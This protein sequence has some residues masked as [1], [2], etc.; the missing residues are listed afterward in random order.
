M[1]GPRNMKCASRCVAGRASNCVAGFGSPTDSFVNDRYGSSSV[2][3]LFRK[4]MPNRA[5]LV[6]FEPNAWMSEIDTVRARSFR[7]SV[8]GEVKVDGSGKGSNPGKFE[9][10]RT[11]L[12]R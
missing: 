7:F 6:R 11:P 12:R 1:R 9:K 8:N 5:S 4:N 3:E 2:R 10:N